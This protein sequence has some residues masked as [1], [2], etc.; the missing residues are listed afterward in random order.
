MQLLQLNHWLW[1][2]TGHL[3]TIEHL[4]DLKYLEHSSIWRARGHFGLLDAKSTWRELEH[5][6]T[7]GGHLGTGHKKLRVIHLGHGCLRWL[8]LIAILLI[9]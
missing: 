9:R 3:K 5:L 4:E 6:R 8:E 7:W 2:V 1:S